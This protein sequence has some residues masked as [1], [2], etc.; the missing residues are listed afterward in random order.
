MSLAEL[1]NTISHHPDISAYIRLIAPGGLSDGNQELFIAGQAVQ[2][3]LQINTAVEGKLCLG[4]IELELVAR[5]GEC[6]GT[7]PRYQSWVAG[8]IQ[9]ART[10]SDALGRIFWTKQVVFQGISWFV[11]RRGVFTRRTWFT[12]LQR[13]LPRKKL[14]A[15]QWTL[16]SSERVCQ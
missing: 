14:I 2:G 10:R 12:A 3:V 8:L 11:G 13:G 4:K 9:D 6:G 15:A 5:E 7:E 1:P 16:S